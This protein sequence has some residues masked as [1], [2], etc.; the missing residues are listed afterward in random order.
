MKLDLYLMS[1]TKLKSKL[2]KDFN[3]RPGALKL[4]EENIGNKLLTSNWRCFFGLNSK[5]KK[6]KN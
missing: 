2:I 5:G 4:L 1:Y 6:S 3:I